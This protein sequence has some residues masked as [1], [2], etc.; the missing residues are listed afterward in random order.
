MKLLDK[1]IKCLIKLKMDIAL[2]ILDKLPPE[3]SKTL[4]SCG[5]LVYDAI[6]EALNE[7]EAA[8]PDPAKPSSITI[9]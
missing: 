3:A 9:D 6:G 2:T 7:H 4:K 1:Q 5:R 8:A